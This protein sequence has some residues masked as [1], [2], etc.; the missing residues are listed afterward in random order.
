MC[1]NQSLLSYQGNIEFIHAENDDN[2]LLKQLRFYG[3]LSWDDCWGILYIRLEMGPRNLQVCQNG[4]EDQSSSLAWQRTVEAVG[5][6]QRYIYAPI[7]ISSYQ[8]AEK[9]K[10]LIIFPHSCISRHV[11]YQVAKIFISILF[12]HF[13]SHI[14][15]QKA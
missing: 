7:Q 6:C 13:S 5:F 15:K 3:Q 11:Q 1:L 14:K 4:L 2:Q 9:L 10:R 8:H 12:Q